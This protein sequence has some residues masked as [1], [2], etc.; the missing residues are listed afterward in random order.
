MNR[1]AAYHE[2]VDNAI[3]AYTAKTQSRNISINLNG[4]EKISDDTFRVDI[5]HAPGKEYSEQQIQKAVAEK[6]DGTFSLV[7]GSIEYIDHPTVSLAT[8]LIVAN[9]ISKAY[10]EQKVEAMVEVSSNVFMDPGDRSMWRSVG[11][12]DKRRLVR[13]N[14]DNYEELL[15]DRISLTPLNTGK[16]VASADDFDV[17]VFYDHDRHELK[18]GLYENTNGVKGRV[19]MPS[20][21]GDTGDTLA[22]YEINDLQIV[23]VLDGA[24]VADQLKSGGAGADLHHEVTAKLSGPQSSTF[25]EYFR[26]LYQGKDFFTRLTQLVK[27]G[28]GTDELFH[29]TTR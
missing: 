9:T 14:Q 25:L 18:A 20:G 5:I 28:A 6:F 24:D 1:Q 13:S 16:T 17:I 27:N 12:G 3:Q 7:P 19:Y 2:S 11:K 26:Q 15:R 22:R 10:D 8:M 4:L 29:G 23:C 21:K